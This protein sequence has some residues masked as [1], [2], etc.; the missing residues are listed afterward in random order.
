MK[1]EK[2][3]SFSKGF[4]IVE[5]LTVIAIMFVLVSFSIP[6]FGSFQRKSDLVDSSEKVINV[7]RLAQSK[8]LA[9]EG[10]SQWGVFFSTSTDPCEL[11]LFKGSSFGLREAV[12]DKVYKLPESIEIFEINLEGGENEVVFNRLTGTTDQFG[13]LFLRL[14]SPQTEERAIFID[15]Y[16]QFSL[17]QELIPSDDERVKDSRRLVFEY[18]RNIDIT[19]ETI[20]LTFTLNGSDF[21]QEIIIAENIRDNQIYWQGEIDT[22]DSLERIKIHTLRLN[23]SD[24]QFCVHRDRRYNSKALKIELS[25][26]FSGAVLEYSADGLTTTKTS[27]YASD[28]QWQ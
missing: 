10:D 12:F 7:L 18:S 27:I 24:S 28:P 6:L 9:S 2:N 23:D 16:G 15:K 14:K 21:S 22:G 26:D 11:I 20:V 17:E 8:T 25:E 4:T 19:I 3:F 5:L 1:K 13:S